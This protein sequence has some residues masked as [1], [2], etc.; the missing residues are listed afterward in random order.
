MEAPNEHIQPSKRCWH[1]TFSVGL[2]IFAWGGRTETK[3]FSRRRGRE[4][5]SAEIAE[6]DP[7]NETW[8]PLPTRGT[9]H[10]G[11]SAAACVAVGDQVYFYGGFDGEEYR[12]VLSKLDMTTLTWSELYA[13][14]AQPDGPTKK[15]ASGLVH[16][17]DSSGRRYLAL[18]GGYG[19]SA[20][21]TRE[22]DV[23]P[24]KDNICYKEDGWTDEFHVFNLDTSMWLSLQ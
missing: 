1:T 14:E 15:V 24:V 20:N 11:L 16:F 9:P 18:F 19:K 23:E 21:L 17:T 7:C 12:G 4:E 3:Q 22:P 8:R 6:F 13:E 2:R 10:P 5:L